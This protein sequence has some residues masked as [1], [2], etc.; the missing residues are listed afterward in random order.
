MIGLFAHGAIRVR[1]HPA[2]IGPTLIRETTMRQRFRLRR[3]LTSDG[4][5][6]VAVVSVL[7]VAGGL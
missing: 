1:R 4:M 7:L 3:L 6:A 5:I 2:A